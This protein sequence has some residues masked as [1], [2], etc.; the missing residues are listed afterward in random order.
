[1]LRKNTLVTKPFLAS[2]NRTPTGT[3]CIS[4]I[5]NFRTNI[6]QSRPSG[7]PGSKLTVEMLYFI[8]AVYDKRLPGHTSLYI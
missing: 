3:G 1:L 2:F 8:N 7:I 5:I 4:R 6:V